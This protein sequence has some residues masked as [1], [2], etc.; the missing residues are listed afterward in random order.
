M[1]WKRMRTRNVDPLAYEPDAVQTTSEAPSSEPLSM[2]IQTVRR[3]RRLGGLLAT[4][5]IETGTVSVGQVLEVAT[6]D[7]TVLPTTC[8]K[9]VVLRGKV[10]RARAG[11]TIGALLS[12]VTKDQVP[13]GSVLRA[14]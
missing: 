12:N 14:R 6:P 4:G 8:M 7:G 1:F 2:P 10:R 13:P 9:L 3:M 11:S 5:E